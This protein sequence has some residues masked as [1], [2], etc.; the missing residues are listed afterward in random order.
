M[1]YRENCGLMFRAYV[2]FRS[3]IARYHFAVKTSTKF[4]EVVYNC[5]SENCEFKCYKI[6]K[7]VSHS[8]SHIKSG[9]AIK[10]PLHFTCKV[11]NCFKN[12]NALRNHMLRRHSLETR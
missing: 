6:N 12:S 11:R 4:E 1:L 5:L 8:C 10:C 9:I 7:I 2:S 3:H